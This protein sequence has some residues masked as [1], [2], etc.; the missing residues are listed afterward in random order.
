MP[1]G[2]PLLISRRI[3]TLSPGNI[4]NFEIRRQSGDQSAQWTD[5]LLLLFPFRLLA[6]DLF[7]LFLLQCCFW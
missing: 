7:L 4:E 3:I 6:V 2:K 5:G 1:T